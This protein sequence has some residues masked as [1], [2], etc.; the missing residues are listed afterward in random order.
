LI[1]DERTKLPSN[2]KNF[3]NANNDKD[4][5][6]ITNKFYSKEKESNYWNTVNTNIEHKREKDANKY[7]PVLK[8]AESMV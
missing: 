3:V 5:N 8:Y 1:K 2:K 4:F 6:V 7:P